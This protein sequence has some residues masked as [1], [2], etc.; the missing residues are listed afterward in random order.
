MSKCIIWK[1]AKLKGGY[2]IVRLEGRT[3]T[4]H[5]VAYKKEHGDI[6]EGMVI[7]HLCDNPSCVNPAHLQ[8][9]TQSQNRQDCVNKG[10]TNSPS[11]EAHYNAKLTADIVLEIRSSTLNNAQL[12]N[13]YGISRRTI[14]DAR[15]GKTWR[16]I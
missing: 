4:A 9:G 11:G 15:R 14:S 13:I 1:G 10:R 12:A 3:Q 16:N 5:R 6:P 2:G 8:L 7:M